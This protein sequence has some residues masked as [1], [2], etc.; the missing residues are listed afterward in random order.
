MSITYT[1]QV[2]RLASSRL[3]V[4][5]FP[6]ATLP[7]RFNMRS[8]MPPIYEQFQLGSCTANALVA[9]YEYL[10]PNFMGSRMFLYY[11]ERLIENDVAEDNGAHICNGV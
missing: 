2:N 11:N 7:M 8:K 10:T 4:A 5:T 1:L 6:S 3:Q 9:C